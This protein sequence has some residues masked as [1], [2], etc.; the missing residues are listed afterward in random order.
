LI[1]LDTDILAIHHIFIWDDRYEVNE[2]VLQ[3]L[4]KEK[5][6]CTTIHNILELCGLYA[7]AGL[8]KKINRILEIYLSSKEIKVIFPEEVLDWGD[9]VALVLQYI[10]RGIPYSDS[11]IALTVEQH[12]VEIF[13]TWNV[14]HFKG[15]IEPEV[16]TPSEYMTKY[17]NH[18]TAKNEI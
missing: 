16:L 15:K 7:I 13:L 5:K 17:M 2:K 12:D 11:L 9:Y 3:R 14:K 18:R 4:K 6:L 1:C 8:A 10:K